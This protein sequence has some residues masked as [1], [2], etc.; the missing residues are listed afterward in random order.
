MDG[1]TAT[2]MIRAYEQTHNINETPIIA[3]TASVLKQ[4]HL[5]AKNAGMNGFTNKPIDQLALNNEIARVLNIKEL[6]SNSASIEL[7]STKR[8]EIHLDKG[9]SLWGDRTLYITELQNFAKRNTTQLEILRSLLSDEKYQD[10]SQ[11]AH[12]IKGASA[13]L[14]LVN[15]SQQAANL[16]NK[17]KLTSHKSCNESL[18]KLENAFLNFQN[19]LSQLDIGMRYEVAPHPTQEECNLEHILTLIEELE[20]LANSGELDDEKMTRLMNC[21]P[22]SL[23]V[24]VNQVI[25][26]LSNFDFELGK[27]QLM[28]LKQKCVAGNIL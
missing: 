18:L 26:H 13:N 9:L 4:D 2:Q 23:R 3:L 21:T 12:A 8:R 6:A 10:L 16:E 24:Y 22:I 7:E 11:A 28:K 15:L 5:D 25:F 14:A 27:A 17:A 19:E 20:V 1:I